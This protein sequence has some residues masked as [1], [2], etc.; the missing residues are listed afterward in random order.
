[1]QLTD[2]LGCVGE[3]RFSLQLSDQT[4]SALFLL[5]DSARVSQLI[6]AIDVTW[7]VPDSISWYFDKPVWLGNSS[8]W[9]QQFTS[10][11]VG[12]IMVGLRAYYGG[13]FSDSSKTVV[14]YQ[15]EGDIPENKSE[16]MPL[17][18]G[19]KVFPNPG[20][21]N[22]RLQAKLSREATVLIKIYS[23]AT[24]SMLYTKELKGQSYYDLPLGLNLLPTGLYVAILTAGKEQQN[25][26]IIINK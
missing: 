9:S 10:D 3:D 1:M 20:D 22:F 7:P 5:Q 2:S 18:V 25:L 16:Q 6:E 12:I 21:G 13:C 4:L 17:I 8:A 19:W 23:L 11:K 24:N 26:K 15:E 14:F